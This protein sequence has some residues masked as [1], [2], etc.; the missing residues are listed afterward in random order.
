MANTLILQKFMRQITNPNL[1]P[2]TQEECVTF[3][4]GTN[5]F[6]EPKIY[7]T[8]TMVKFS[9]KNRLLLNIINISSL[10]FLTWSPNPQI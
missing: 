2:L 7:T 3:K 6:G 10:D 5:A 9:T 8:N 1:Q 4:E